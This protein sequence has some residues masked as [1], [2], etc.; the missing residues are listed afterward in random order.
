MRTPGHKKSIIRSCSFYYIFW[1]TN[2]WGIFFYFSQDCGIKIHSVKWAA[3]NMWL[4]KSK[5]TH[6]EL[7]EEAFFQS[8]FEM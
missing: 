7:T 8:A 1:K 5:S 2:I 6:K 4:L 3:D